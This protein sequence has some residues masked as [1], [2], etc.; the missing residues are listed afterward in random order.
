MIWVTTPFLVALQYFG[1]DQPIFSS[2]DRNPRNFGISL[3]ILAL[4]FPLL[5]WILTLLYGIRDF[6]MSRLFTKV[7]DGED[8]GGKSNCQHFEPHSYL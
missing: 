7:D 4:A 1:A 2:F 6:V 5:T 8:L 3:C